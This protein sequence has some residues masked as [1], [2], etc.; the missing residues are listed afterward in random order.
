MR[1]FLIL[2][3][4]IFVTGYLELK[5][6][7]NPIQ[8]DFYAVGISYKNADAETRGSFSLSTQASEELIEKAKEKGLEE[9]MINTTCNRTELYAF[10]DSNDSLKELLLEYSQGD[11]KVFDSLGYQ[12]AKEEAINHLFKVGTG[13]DSQILGDFEVISQLKK[14]FYLSKK[15]GMVNGHSERLVN[16]VIQ[17]SKRVKTETKLST[18]ATSVAFAAVQYIL[19]QQAQLD[20]AKI[21]LF[22]TGKIGRNT[23]EN[24]VKHTS[25]NQITLIN[26]TA[27]KASQIGGKF[28]LSVKPLG[29]LAAEIRQTD[30]LIVAT[31]GAHFTVNEELVHLKKPLLIVDLS[32]PRNVDPALNSN[33]LVTLVHLDELSRITDATLIERQKYIPQAEAIINEVKEDYLE[34]V[35]L[36]KYA[37]L[38]QGLKEKWELNQNIEN[39]NPQQQNLLKVTGQIATFL[40]ENPDKAD[41]TAE[42][43]RDLFDLEIPPHV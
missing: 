11:E 13:L 40:R 20:Q 30:V 12:F 27:E 6:M 19:S 4:S 24:L 7:I 31:G 25:N 17:A 26:R 15:K 41:H 14:S 33:E 2:V 3:E 21:L 9:L 8:K 16:A 22:G 23:C 32:I 10:G 34:W 38:L 39:P 1:C 36:R 42:V 37:P 5:T 18:G 28:N 35:R 29:D 43:L